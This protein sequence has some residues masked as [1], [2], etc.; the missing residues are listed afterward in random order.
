[1]TIEAIAI[2]IFLFIAFAVGGCRALDMLSAVKPA[3]EVKPTNYTGPR[4]NA[5]GREME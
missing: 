5:H 4:Y 2:G 1:M 3:R